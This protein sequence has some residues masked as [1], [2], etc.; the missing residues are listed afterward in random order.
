MRKL[1]TIS[2]LEKEAMYA[3][4][5]EDEERDGKAADLC[6]CGHPRSEHVISLNVP[7]CQECPEYE[8]QHEFKAK[9]GDQLCECG[10]KRSEHHLYMKPWHIFEAKGGD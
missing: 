7:W 2:D 6:T 4:S 9:G 10:L 3:A 1:P 8:N 5:R